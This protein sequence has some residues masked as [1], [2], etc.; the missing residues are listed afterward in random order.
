MRLSQPTHI[1]LAPD[2]LQWL[3]SWRGDRMTR[4]TAIRLLLDEAMLLHRDDVTPIN[5]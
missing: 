5:R 3:D 4:A 1:R 2:L